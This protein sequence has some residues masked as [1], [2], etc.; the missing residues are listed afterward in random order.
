MIHITDCAKLL[1]RDGAI[2]T[3]VFSSVFQFKTHKIRKG[4]EAPRTYYRFVFNDIMGL[5][6]GEDNGVSVEDI[7]LAMK[8]CVMEGYKVQQLPVSHESLHST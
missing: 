2:G 1:P 4:R 8:G 6:D 5:E 7:K 3:A